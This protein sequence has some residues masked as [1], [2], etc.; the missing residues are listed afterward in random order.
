MSLR[1]WLWLELLYELLM[2]CTSERCW[3]KCKLQQGQFGNRSNSSKEAQLAKAHQVRR[4]RSEKYPLHLWTSFPAE[5]RSR[6]ETQRH[7]S[8]FFHQK[9]FVLL[10]FSPCFWPEMPNAVIAPMR[11]ADKGSLPMPTHHFFI[12]SLSKVFH[13]DVQFFP[14]LHQSLY[15]QVLLH[16]HLSSPCPNTLKG[17]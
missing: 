14:L 6:K 16:C 7:G 9:S 15:P 2:T 10:C 13:S 4:Q 17:Q 8:D 3:G 11:Q 1:A 5:A 12:F